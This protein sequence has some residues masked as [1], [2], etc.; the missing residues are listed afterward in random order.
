MKYVIIEKWKKR[1]WDFVWFISHLSKLDIRRRWFERK[2]ED[3]KKSFFLNCVKK[4][5]RR[6]WIAIDFFRLLQNL[7][8]MYTFQS[9]SA[10]NWWIFIFEMHSLHSL[11]YSWVVFEASKWRK[12][13]NTTKLDLITHYSFHFFCFSS[14]LK[15]SSL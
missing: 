8:T 12:M 7:A 5:I 2:N 6:S 10:P 1:T 3:K 14:K 11:A 9:Q 13:K 15:L 4:S